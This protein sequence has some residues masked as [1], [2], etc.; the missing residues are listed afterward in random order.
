MPLSLILFDQFPVPVKPQFQMYKKKMT[1]FNI[2]KTKSG[3]DVKDLG[4]N[5]TTDWN[6][7]CFCCYLYTEVGEDQKGVLSFSPDCRSL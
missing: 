7:L 3:Y 6:L 4:K 2:Y 1:L 5:M